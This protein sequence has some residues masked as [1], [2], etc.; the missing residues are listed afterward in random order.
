[1]IIS[2]AGHAFIG[3]HNTVKESVKRHIK[4]NAVM[5]EPMYC[6]LGGYGEFDEICAYACRELKKE[7][8]NIVLVYVTPYITVSAQ[9]KIKESQQLR[10]YDASIYP[11]IEN[12]CHRLAIIKRNEWMMASA[13][14]VIAYVSHNYG[15]AY[16][17]LQAAKRNK[18][19][20]INIC[21]QP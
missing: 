15:G 5:H 13:D 1:M 19:R 11:P 2:F 7:F 21:N 18:K 17:S 12:C 14:L 3:S 9:E 4:E 20:I 6:Y 16:R 10:L 8:S